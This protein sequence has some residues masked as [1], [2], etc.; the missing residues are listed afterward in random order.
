MRHRSWTPGIVLHE[1]D[2][3]V[4]KGFVGPTLFKRFGQLANRLVEHFGNKSPAIFTIKP[5]PA[6]REL[7]KFLVHPLRVPLLL[8]WFISVEITVFIC[9]TPYSPGMIAA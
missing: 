6:R 7:K 1:R 5:F 2:V 4:P 9:L 3:F 8:A